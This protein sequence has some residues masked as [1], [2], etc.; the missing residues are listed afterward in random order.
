M[1]KNVSQIELITKFICRQKDLMNRSG[2]V[3]ALSGGLDSAVVA[4]LVVKALGIQNVTL[5]NLPERDS[6]PLHQRH[7]KDFAESLH[8]K[9]IKH[10]IT[11]ILFATE[12][13]RFLPISLLP[14]KSLRKSIVEYAR[15][16]VLKKEADQLL[17]TRLNAGD[18]S[19]EARANAYAMAKHRIR[20]VW[21]YQFAERHNLMVVGAANKTE[22]LTGTF[23]K[24]GIDHCADIMPIMHLYRTQVEEIAQDLGIPANI[25]LKPADP[26]LLPGL[27]DKNILLGDPKMVDEILMAIENGKPKRELLK[28]FD[29]VLAEKL[30][31]LVAHSEHMRKSPY[32]L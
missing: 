7:A 26:D 32:H 21:T 16:K 20:M 18:N 14:T 23:S 25:R 27:A 31:Y 6:N 3:L 22:W 15:R 19:W 28:I 5:I 1:A 30:L 9:F 11:G 24:W 17:Q 29:G 8:C 13:Y 2:A 10:S 12:T 4:S